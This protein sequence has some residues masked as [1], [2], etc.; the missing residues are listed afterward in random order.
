MKNKYYYIIFLLLF[1]TSLNTVSAY[2]C[3]QESANTTNQTGID[4][5]CHLNYAGFYNLNYFNYSSTQSWNWTNSS[6]AND[7]NILSYSPNSCIGTFCEAQASLT[8]S[9]PPEVQGAIWSWYNG[10]TWNN[11]TFSSYYI[12][13]ISD[14]INIHLRFFFGTLTIGPCIDFSNNSYCLN[15]MSN[16]VILSTNNIFYEEK[17]YW[18]VTSLNITAKNIS[19]TS[20]NS[21]NVSIKNLNTSTQSYYNTTTGLITANVIMGNSY[22]ITFDGINYALNYQNTTIINNSQ[23]IS[24]TLYPENSI[25]ITVK[26]EA[27][28][29]LLNSNTTIMITGNTTQYNYIINNGSILISGLIPDTYTLTLTNINT[30]YSVRTYIITMGGK[31]SQSLITYLAT[32]T[33][34][35]VFTYIDT[36]TGSPIS[37]ILAIMYGYI[38]GSLQPV[39]SQISDTTGRIQWSFRTNTPYQFYSQKNLYNSKLVLFSPSILYTAYNIPMIKTGFVTTLNDVNIYYTPQTLTTTGSNNVK[40]YFQS[41]NGLLTYYQYSLISSCYSSSKSNVNSNGEGF[42][43]NISIPSCTDANMILI[44]T[45]NTSTG[46]IS[47]NTF[48]IPIIGNIGNYIILNNSQQ[49]FGMGIFERTLIVVLITL[50]I[51]GVA[52]LLGGL[53]AGSIVGLFILAYFSVITNFI[54]PLSATIILFIGLIL[55][56][57]KAVN[58]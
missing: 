19:G 40:I 45:Y 37:N 41:P 28:N 46:I 48:N 50:V 54:N 1:I 9:K 27:T 35:T 11:I 34:N 20:I 5:N 31:S 4:G 38:N 22:L 2:F 39:S 51:G 33:Q 25:N 16:S 7:G 10:T 8:Y 57:S 12:N 15:N 23:I 17:M 55:L 26:D 44:T 36:S 56:M 13:A 43:L 58:Q 18:N 53:L 24:E 29:T 52:S 42:M 47:S 49:T 6:F 21:F 30:N 32:G 3:Y 14:V